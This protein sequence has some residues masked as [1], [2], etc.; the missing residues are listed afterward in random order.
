MW[1]CGVVEQSPVFDKDLR[2]AQI[3][4]DFTVKEFVSELRVEALAVS[5][6]PR[7][8]RLDIECADIQCLQPFTQGGGDKLW[9]IIGSDMLW[10]A[11]LRE[12]LAERVEDITGVQSALNADR[13]TL[14]RILIDDAKHAEDLAVMRAVL[15]EVIGPDMAFVGGPQPNA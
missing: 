15:D 11:V 9:P 7:R 3:I 1:S 6:F 4:E 13:Q 10:W 12:Q 2:L 8:P 14:S 5:V